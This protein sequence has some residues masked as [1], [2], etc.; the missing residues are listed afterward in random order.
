MS[1]IRI[2]EHPSTIAQRK[3]FAEA[4]PPITDRPL[5]ATDQMAIYYDDDLVG[6]ASTN[7]GGCINLIVNFSDEDANAI[8]SEVSQ[9]MNVNHDKLS[10]MP[11][12]PDELLDQVE[13]LEE[14]DDEISE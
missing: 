6:Y 3:Q 8:K 11:L 13:G 5:A 2:D 12:V 9:M 14:D 1:D 4:V 7:E 10:V